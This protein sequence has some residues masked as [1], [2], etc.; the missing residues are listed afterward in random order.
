VV[1]TRLL[2]KDMVGSIAPK[3]LKRDVAI[4]GAATST[5]KPKKKAGAGGS[6]AASKVPALSAEERAAVA[7]KRK[8]AA[9]RR[10]AQLTAQELQA[11]AALQNGSYDPK[12]QLPAA[13]IQR[14]ASS[15]AAKAAPQAASASP[16]PPAAKPVVSYTATGQRVVTHAAPQGRPVEHSARSSPSSRGTSPAIS[17]QQRHQSPGAAA[18]RTDSPAGKFPKQRRERTSGLARP[19]SGKPHAP[20]SVAAPVSLE[21]HAAPKAA[22]RS[23]TC[24]GAGGKQCRRCGHARKLTEFFVDK[25][26]EDGFMHY[27]VPC[28]RHNGLSGRLA[29]PDELAARRTGAAAAVRH[30]PPAGGAAA[31]RAAFYAAS[32]GGAGGRPGAARSGDR[33][34]AP[35]V[36]S[37][38]A[39][40]PQKR[41]REHVDLDR[42][43][44]DFVEDD[45]GGGSEDDWRKEL[46]EV[47]A[48]E[49]P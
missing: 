18:L 11:S 47:R 46:A 5:E 35:A 19:A 20:V 43:D 45:V 9:E 40:A 23:A 36:A 13:L 41:R 42:Y 24:V 44:D 7:A 48:S 29:T 26:T 3:P 4:K 33:A 28:A 49:P 2:C 39:G 1:S 30:V 8:A 31:P 27:C 21:Y 22:Q 15:P 34:V 12:A 10:R 37:V 38:R 14:R 25:R 6:A 16:R 32:N 17:Q